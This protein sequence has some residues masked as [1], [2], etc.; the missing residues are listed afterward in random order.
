MN[1]SIV[2]IESKA[3]LFELEEKY[4]SDK[5]DSQIK[6]QKKKIEQDRKNQLLLFTLLFLSIILFVLSF[7]FIRYRHKNK[8]KLEQALKNKLLIEKFIE[9]EEKERIRIAKDLHDGIVQ[10]LTAIYMQL[11]QLDSTN[12]IDKKD[13][14]ASYL[15]QTSHEL[16]NLSHEMMPI[17]LQ[18][19]GLVAAL[20]ELF[21]RTAESSS[22]SFSFDAFKVQEN[23]PKKIEISLYRI[24]QELIN[25]ILKHSQASDVTC[26]LKQDATEI[27]LILEDNGIG[28][29]VTSIKQGIGFE[30]LQS[31]LTFINGKLEMSSLEDHVQGLYV[32][33]R[34]PV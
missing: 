21:V 19:K 9:G 30:S 34:I 12:V 28:F 13:K 27:T 1:D 14:I 11:N 26:I 15:K 31:R 17:V 20:E 8:L 29:Q 3:A 25:N 23:L 10:D 16:R 32:V 18:Q 24:V 5:K 33:I 22:I 4:E 7:L 2:G 6:A